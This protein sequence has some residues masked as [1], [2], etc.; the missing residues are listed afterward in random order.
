MTISRIDPSVTPA[1]QMRRRGDMV[2][3]HTTGVAL[4]PTEASA[5][6][7]H[8]FSRPDP[9]FV[10]HLI[11]MAEGSPQTR[12]LRRAAIADVEAAYTTAANRNEP[13]MPAGALTRRSA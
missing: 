8:A 7:S 9:S 10:A 1:P 11:A 5:A 4:V 3:D 2:Q 12:L 13:I 6:A